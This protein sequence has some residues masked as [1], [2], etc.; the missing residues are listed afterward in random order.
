MVN[1]GQ[2]A[3]E[4]RLRKLLTTIVRELDKNFSY[5]IAAKNSWVMACIS[6]SIA[7]SMRLFADQ[8]ERDG[9]LLRKIAEGINE[10]EPDHVH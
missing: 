1:P 8:I 9:D 4:R 7:N 5:A 10:E 3:C 2:V 6:V